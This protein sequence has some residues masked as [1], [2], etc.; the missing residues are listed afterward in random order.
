[1]TER[2][3]SIIKPDAVENGNAGSILAR[4]EGSGLK[5]VAS[6]MTWLSRPKAREFYAVHKERPFFDSLVDYMV[7]GP[8]IV[9]VLEA[10]NAIQKHRDILGATN[11][12]DAAEGTVRKDYGESIERN[13]THGSDGTDTA[14]TE[15]GHFFA[16]IELFNYERK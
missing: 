4:F 6:K 1:M 14:K 3:L 15:I 13:A 8:I 12:A 11:P 16:T 5:I 2:T 10:N 9:S 7:S